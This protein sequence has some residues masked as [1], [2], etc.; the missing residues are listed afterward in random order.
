M[1]PVQYSFPS[2]EHCS[3]EPLPDGF[4]DTGK[5]VANVMF[6][7]A[8][9]EWLD[10]FALLVFDLKVTGFEYLSIFAGSTDCVG[11]LVEA[12]DLGSDIKK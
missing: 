6:K 7:M 2:E 8:Q 4:G 10:V 11:D 1:P 12:S 9:K 5:P 3:S